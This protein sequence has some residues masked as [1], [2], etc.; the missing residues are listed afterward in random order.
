MKFQLRIQPSKTQT[1]AMP[2][3]EHRRDVVPVSLENLCL[4][5]HVVTRDWRTGFILS[6][7][8]IKY[9]YQALTWLG[10]DLC[11]D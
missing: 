4:R 8:N 5:C 10:P 3:E 1:T 2:A 6:T 11:R 9:C 7:M